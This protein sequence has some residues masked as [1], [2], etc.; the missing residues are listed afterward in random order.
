[1]PVIFHVTNYQFADTLTWVKGKHLVKFGGDLLRTQFF[2]P[3]YN[4]NRG[5]YI[6]NGYWT[7][8][9]IADFELGVLNQVTRTVGT[10]PNYLFFNNWGFFAQDDWRVSPSLTLNV[11][12]ALRNSHAAA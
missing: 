8:V 3:Y 9:P 10:N 11:G 5:T 6:F 7:S 2:Q 4:N 12:L 1:M